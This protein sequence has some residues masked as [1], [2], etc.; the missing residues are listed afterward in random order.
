MTGKILSLHTV[1]G[2]AWRRQHIQ[3]FMCVYVCVCVCTV[4]VFKIDAE[5][6]KHINANAED[7]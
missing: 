6:R 3:T 1:L 5:L 4:R 2:S 7:P